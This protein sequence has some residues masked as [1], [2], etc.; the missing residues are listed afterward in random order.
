MLSHLRRHLRLA[1]A[2]GTVAWAG[3]PG[4]ASAQDLAK[5]TFLEGTASLNS[6]TLSG[7]DRI[8]YVGSPRISCSD[9]VRITADS[10]VTYSAQN[11]SYLIGNVR[12]QDSVRTMTSDQARYFSQLGRL[13]AGGNLFV[14]DTVQGSVIENGFL[15]YLRKTDSRAEEEMT[16][17]IGPDQI[18]PTAVLYMKPGADTVTAEPLPDTVSAEPVPDTTVA[19]AFRD[20]VA[21]EP[22]VGTAVPAD[23]VQTPYHVEGDRLFLKGDQFFNASGDVVIVHDSLTAHS[24]LAEYDQLSARLRLEGSAHVVGSGYDLTASTIDIGVPGGRMRSVR[25]VHQAVLVG[26]ALHLTAPVIQILTREGSMDR[27]IA[28]RLASDSTRAST[29]GFARAPAQADTADLVRP[30]ATAENF[31]LTADSIDVNA[32]DQVLDR[33]LAS[34]AARGESSKRDSLNTG[35]LPEIARKDWMEGDTVIA[36]FLKVEPGPGQPRDSANY[37]LQRLIA[38][39]QAR[40]LYR[41]L[42]ADSSR[43]RPGIDPP[44]VSYIVGAKIEIVMREGEVDSMNV[45]G[46]VKGWQLEPGGR[47]AKGDSAAADTTGMLPDTL[48]PGTPPDTSATRTPTAAARGRRT[49]LDRESGR[50]PRQGG[51]DSARPTREP[52]AR[53]RRRR[54]G[55]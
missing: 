13:Q 49:R 27:L 44:A 54:K 36:T 35:T 40:S 15:I 20:T 18:R 51:S 16:V 5:C 37:E 50:N 22:P 8:T 28:V 4:R 2:L 47:R 30:V 53:E 26:D 52:V 19:G 34:G 9:G 7:G 33:I 23:T 55:W 38:H 29:L 46:P 6:I 10:A 32:P 21:A 45:E 24:Q 14:R 31:V 12:Y 3:V 41:L 39:G 1:A 17:T 42:P 43:A 25:A 11:M 48:F